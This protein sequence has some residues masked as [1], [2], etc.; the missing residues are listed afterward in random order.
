VGLDT[1]ARQL[2][3]TPARFVTS[4]SSSF[5]GGIPLI[6]SV[7]RSA[8]HGGFSTPCH[9]V[10]FVSQDAHCSRDL[11][12]QCEG[13]AVSADSSGHTADHIMMKIPIPLASAEVEAVSRRARDRWFQ[14]DSTTVAAAGVGV[15]VRAGAPSSRSSS[16]TNETVYAAATSRGIDAASAAT[17]EVQ[18]IQ[19]AQA[20]QVVSITARDALDHGCR[21]RNCN[22]WIMGKRFQCAN[23]PSEPEPYNLVRGLQTSRTVYQTCSA[24]THLPVLHLRAPVVPDP[25]PPPRVFQ[26]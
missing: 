24:L 14:Q 8:R 13:V 17:N 1:D 26:V 3:D 6:L 10:S 9:R 5:G 11:C 12:I 21:C 25:R 2:C 23:C 20:A 7:A 22:E 19:T 16:P 15:G 18:T 4:A